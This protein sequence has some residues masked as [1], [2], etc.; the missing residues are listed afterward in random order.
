M[1]VCAVLDTMAWGWLS[2]YYL[3][4]DLVGVRESARKIARKGFFRQ[5]PEVQ[6]PWGRSV[7]SMVE[8]QLVQDWQDWRR[9]QWRKWWVPWKTSLWPWEELWLDSTWGREELEG[10]S[11]DLTHIL[12]HLTGC[13]VKNRVQVGRG[14]HRETLGRWPRWPRLA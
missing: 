7:F 11:H 4:G 13:G 9:E 10:L 6:K 8:Q 14:H 3:S 5:W 12:Q 2:E 1:Y